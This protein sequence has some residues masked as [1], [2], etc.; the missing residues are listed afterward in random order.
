MSRF[1]ICLALAWTVL[2]C[3]PAIDEEPPATAPVL[4]D[5][6]GSIDRVLMVV[7][8]PYVSW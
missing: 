8:S 4:A 3:A 6:G 1:C 7:S 2:A 5:A